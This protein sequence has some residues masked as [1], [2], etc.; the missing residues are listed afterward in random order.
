MLNGECIGGYTK[1]LWTSEDEDKE[2]EDKGAM[3][4]NLTTHASFPCIKPST[5]IWCNKYRGP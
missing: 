5:A 1:A 2:E 4:F 3:L